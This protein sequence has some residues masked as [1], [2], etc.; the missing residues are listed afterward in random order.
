M[1]EEETV[2][3]KENPT[4]TEEELHMG[5]FKEWIEPQVRDAIITMY[6]KGYATQSSGFHGTK[7]ELQMI[8]GYF[9]I[10]EATK[11]RL[12]QMGVDVLRGVDIG[13]PQ[14]KGVRMLG[15]RAKDPSIKQI[16]AQWDA[17]AAVLPRKSFPPGISPICD[18]AEEFREQYAPTH[19]SFEA[20]R[21]AYFEYLKNE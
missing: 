15:F 5:A 3:L 14:N 18:R 16:K 12:N 17:V 4:P 8:D 20:K 2:R 13:I 6:R 1:K 9:R 11:A 19:P 10:D 7:P 21:K